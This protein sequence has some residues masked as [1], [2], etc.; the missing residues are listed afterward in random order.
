MDENKIEEL[1]PELLESITGGVS[2]ANT[3]DKIKDLILAMKKSG[4]HKEIVAN[5]FIRGAFGPAFKIPG[6]KEEV[7]EYVNRIWILE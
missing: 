2:L 5:Y 6:S 4:Y 3:Q 7:M 1:S